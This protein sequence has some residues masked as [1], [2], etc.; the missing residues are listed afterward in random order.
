[1]EGLVITYLVCRSEMPCMQECA[2]KLRNSCISAFLVL[3]FG[4]LSVQL[5]ALFLLGRNKKS[6]LTH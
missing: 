1:M 2:E 3:N 5:S 6:F 4:S